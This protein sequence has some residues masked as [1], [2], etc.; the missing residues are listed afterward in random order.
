M[1]LFNKKLIL[2]FL[3]CSLLLSFFSVNPLFFVCL[4]TVVFYFLFLNQSSDGLYKKVANIEKISGAIERNNVK[5]LENK[6]HSFIELIPI[7]SFPQ[8]KIVFYYCHLYQPHR[9]LMDHQKKPLLDHM[10]FFECLKF[11]SKESNLDRNMRYMID[12]QSIIFEDETYFDLFMYHLQNHTFKCEQ[13]IFNIEFIYTQIYKEK[14]NQLLE[15]N[16]DFNVFNI[17]I[18][19]IEPLLNSP[20]AANIFSCQISQSQLLELMKDELMNERIHNF[21]GYIT[22]LLI[23][24]VE[25]LKELDSLPNVVDFVSGKCFSKSITVAI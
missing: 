9:F 2:F 24:D 6:I 4:Q 10:V 17:T 1:L 15:F 14:I 7:V 21:H 12:L 22:R 13:V 25:D 23:S 8:K 3:S 19:N 18:D 5:P 16:I 20:F 11:L